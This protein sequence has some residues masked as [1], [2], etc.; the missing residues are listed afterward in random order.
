MSD[1][2]TESFICI[3]SPE[4]NHSTKT[5][6]R[7]HSGKLSSQG[8]QSFLPL[9]ASHTS[10]GKEDENDSRTVIRQSFPHSPVL[11]L[12]DEVTSLTAQDPGEKLLLIPTPPWIPTMGQPRQQSSL[13]P[14]EDD[15]GQH[16]WGKQT[17]AVNFLF[18]GKKGRKTLFSIQEPTKRSLEFHISHL[19]WWLN[20]SISLWLLFQSVC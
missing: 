19:T 3:S 11:V 7:I 10:F 17:W 12:S 4:L 1:E 13:T 16:S 2:N 6:V 9:P 15:R 5:N 8:L 14:P 20:Y 18:T